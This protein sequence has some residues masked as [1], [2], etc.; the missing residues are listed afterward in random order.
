MEEGVPVLL[1]E[2]ADVFLPAEVA[3]F[4]CPCHLQVVDAQTHN[5][6]PVRVKLIET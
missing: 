4:P 5:L 1:D 3:V 2:A 6:Q